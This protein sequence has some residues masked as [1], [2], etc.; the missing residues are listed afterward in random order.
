MCILTL[1]C[2]KRENLG[3]NTFVSVMG[4]YFPTY[5]A[6]EIEDI[7]RKINEEEFEQI[8]NYIYKLNLKNGYIQYLE[9]NEEQYVPN[10]L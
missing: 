5:K 1:T 4:Q 10:F 6:N 8:E 7:N 2:K 9:D 3:K